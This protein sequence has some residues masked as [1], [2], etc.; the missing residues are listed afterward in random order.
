MHI[1]SEPVFSR[2]QGVLRPGLQWGSFY[3]KLPSN[4]HSSPCGILVFQSTRRTHTVS[5]QFMDEVHCMH[6]CV[7]YTACVYCTVYVPAVRRCPQEECVIGISSVS[8][9]P[10]ALQQICSGF[11]W[12]VCVC[13]CCKSTKKKKYSATSTTSNIWGS[14]SANLYCHN[15]AK[16][17]KKEYSWFE[18]HR[19]DVVS[20]TS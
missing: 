3:A 4:W 17:E 15:S 13:E 11:V 18:W 6:V 19:S 7:P 10:W 2:S 9:L 16:L 20:I 14:G 5:I 1:C 12:C 8:W